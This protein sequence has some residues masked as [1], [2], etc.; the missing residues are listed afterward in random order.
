MKKMKTWN[1]LFVRHGWV[2]ERIE[3]NVFDC[4]NE[5]K[6]NL[7]FLL[8]CL[9]EAGVQYRFTG[10][11]LE[12]LENTFDENLLIPVLE[13]EERGV[14]GRV[15]RY[16]DKEQLVLRDLD[17]YI[18][19]V[20]RQL[21][22]LGF[23]T[24]YSCDGHERR[25]PFIAILKD[26]DINQL[27]ELLL[28]LG[29]ASR[30]NRDRRQHDT[31]Y[32]QTNRTFLLDLAESLS[33]VEPDWLTEGP[34]FIKE[35]LFY[36]MLEELLNVPGAS[37]NEEAIRAVVKEKLAPFVD[38]MTTDRHGN[39]LA[40]KVYRT[41][42]GPVIMLNAHLDIVTELVPGRQIVKEDGVW[43]SDKGILGADDRAGVAITLQI[44]KNLAKSSFNGKVKFVFTVKEECGLVG[45]SLVD[46]YFLWDVDAAFVVD[47]RGT[48]DIVTS[49]GGY[50][51][52]CNEAFGHCIEEIAER[53]ATGKWA[54]TAG[55]SSDTRI[56]AAHGIQSVNLSVG[57]WNEHTEDESLDVGACY[58]TVS[59]LEGVFEHSRDIRTIARRTGLQDVM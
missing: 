35:E 22:R 39:L 4:K 6:A 31:V 32:L 11:T 9:N 21:E 49:C 5:T 45:A 23:P 24:V 37:G 13:C 30:V 57:Y 53:T 14:T 25:R 54:C 36:I 47:R 58:Q 33:L 12:F 55:G 44:A 3:G 43:R 56:W 29:V 48:G 51:P 1:Q 42:N 40:E 34:D 27:E 18:S 16:E 46:E 17:T 41:G 50:I 15:G 19:G 52:F 20:V 10:S 7:A 26:G 38:R 59:L 28:V 2:M 8:D